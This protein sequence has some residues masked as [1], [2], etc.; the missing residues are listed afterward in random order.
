M[1]KELKLK[2]L[3]W[4]VAEPLPRPT[5]QP[6]YPAIDKPNRARSMAVAVAIMIVIDSVAAIALW[7]YFDWCGMLG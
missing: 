4:I 5:T 3:V 1:S 6:R 2:D 7:P